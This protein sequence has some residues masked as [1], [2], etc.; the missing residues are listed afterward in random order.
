MVVDD[1]LPVRELLEDVFNSDEV[2]VASFADGETAMNYM[3]SSSANLAIIDIDLG[4]GKMNG[5]EVCKAIRAEHPHLP[6][7][8]LSGERGG[9]AE[10]KAK[11][12]GADDF[13]EKDPHLAE[14]LTLSVDKVKRILDLVGEA[15]RL[16]RENK[17]LRDR[18]ASLAQELGHRWNIVGNSDS[19]QGVLEKVRRVAPVPRPV[20]ILGE[21]GTGKELV[22]RALHSLSPKSTAPFVTINCAAVPES[23]LESELF[24][25]EQGAFTGATTQKQGKLEQADGGTLFLDEVGD[26]SLSFQAKLLRAL[27]IQRFERVAG[28]EAIQVSVRVI[29]ATNVDLV[30]AIAEKKFRAD[31]YDRLS[32]EVLE[33]PPLRERKEDIPELAEHFLQ[34]FG[35]EFIGLRVRGFRKESLALLQ[36]YDFPGNVRELKNIVE[37]ALYSAN[38]D[39]VEKEEMAAAIPRVQKAQRFTDDEAQPLPKR[40]EAFERQ[41]CLEA[42]QETKFNQKEAAEKLGITYDQFRQRY[43]KYK[44]GNT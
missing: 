22:A 14:T 42:L 5:L 23:L 31:L 16:R 15:S 29:A 36:S 35:E 21:R 37:R 43:K 33:L 13:I 26:M 25:H 38:G 9:N 24:G 34:R 11:E 3:A 27:E 39:H 2:H 10:Q 18:N 17:N 1:Q 6:I 8:I 12:A 44:L 4:P 30:Q 40:V 7:I 28:N 19:I 41:I 20:L 32:F